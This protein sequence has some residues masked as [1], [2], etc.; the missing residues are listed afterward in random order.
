MVLFKF[1][2]GYSLIK[3]SYLS[4]LPFFLNNKKDFIKNPINFKKL[5]G[6]YFLKNRILYKS[7][8]KFTPNFMAMILVILC[9]NSGILMLSITAF[10][11]AY[12]NKAFASFLGIPRDCM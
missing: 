2:C 3:I 8:P 6:F 5:I 4:L 12:I 11:N 10:E 7:N 1:F 9:F